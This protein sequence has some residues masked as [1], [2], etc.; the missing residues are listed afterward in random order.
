M[1]YIPKEQLAAAMAADPVPRFRTH[2]A[3]AGVCGADELDRIDQEALARVED[4]L[5]TVMGA[6]PPSV[7]ELDR[8]V[9]A[10]PIGFPV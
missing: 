7:D 4:A 1:P 2:L 8:D 9:Y 3:Q 5:A 10:T 6:E